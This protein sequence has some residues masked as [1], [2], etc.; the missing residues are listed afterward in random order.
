[1]AARAGGLDDLAR[2]ALAVLELGLGR[3]PEALAHVRSTFDGDRPGAATRSLHEI[4]EAGVRSGDHEAAKAALARMDERAPV[5][6]TAWGLGLLARCR[7]LMA[8]DDQ[9]EALYR[10]STELLGRTRIRTELARSHLLYGEWLRRRRRRADARV[11]LRT[12]HEMFTRMGAAA[13]AGRA[14][15]DLLATGE[16]PSP[17]SERSDSG[18]T[19]QER[20]VAGLAAAGATNSEIA[21][22]LFLSTSTVEYHLTRIFRKLAITSRRR[23][24][25]ALSDGA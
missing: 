13:F 17:R 22:R 24:A 3:Y 25:A 16:R 6:G 21:A 1:M 2:N 15:S 9:A 8:D 19:P 23:L 18:L 4:V 11:Q 10:E 20:Q 12:A 5:S 14:R 7:A